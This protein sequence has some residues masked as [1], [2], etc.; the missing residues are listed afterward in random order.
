MNR[1]HCVMDKQGVC[2]TSFTGCRKFCQM[3][4]QANDN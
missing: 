3:I 2:P 4:M 1:M